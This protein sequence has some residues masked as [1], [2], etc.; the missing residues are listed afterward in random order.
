MA[1]RAAAAL[2]L[3]QEQIR[4]VYIGL[5][6]GA[7]RPASAD[8]TWTRRYGD[9]KAK[10]ALLLALL[11]E[12]GI[13]A[14]AVLVNSGGGDGMDERLPALGLFDHVVVRAV[15]DGRTVWLDGTRSGD[16]RLDLLPPP[17]FV[18]ALP[19]RAADATLEKVERKPLVRPTVASLIE[20][21]LSKGVGEPAGLRGEMYLRQDAAIAFRQAFESKPRADVDRSLRALWTQTYEWLEPSAV[22]WRWD[23]R[24]G[25][26]TLT[27]VG[28]GEP[29]WDTGTNAE[30]RWWW[31]E[32][33]QL[34]KPSDFKRPKD[35]DQKA[36]FALPFPSYARQTIVV[37]FPEDA[38]VTHAW[39]ADPIGVSLAGLSLRRNTQLRDRVLLTSSSSRTLSPEVSAEDVATAAK[40]WDDLSSDPVS[41]GIGPVMRRQ[42]KDA[43]DRA[44]AEIRTAGDAVSLADVYLYDDWT[45]RGEPMLDRALALDPDHVDALVRKAELLERRDGPDAAVGVLEKALARI[46]ELDVA[47]A[48]SE[49]HA[50]A[51]RR[52]HATALLRSRL[53]DHPNDADLRTALAARLLID[54]DPAAA[55]EQLNVAD[56]LTGV[57]PESERLRGEALEYLERYEEAYAHYDRML[58][59][60]PDVA[61]YNLYRGRVSSVL[62]RNEAALDDL[63]E[64]IRIDPL[65]PRAYAEK[66][67]LLGSLGRVDDAIATAEL[68]VRRAPKSGYASNLRCWVKA[69]A[70]RDL[71]GAE[72]DCETASK[73]LPNEP[74]VQDSRALLDFRAG[75]LDEAR[76][77]YDLILAGD[78]GS[79]SA[80]YGRGL[81]RLKAGDAAG[82]RADID[83]AKA[84]DALTVADY[85]AF[86]LVEEP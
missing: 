37:R 43:L 50:R 61:A 53:K 68:G 14:E 39:K 10:T 5:D 26:L 47:V 52:E 7:Y 78:P 25:E 59:A 72:K 33:T 3:V 17:T 57:T 55:L 73:R 12:L 77:K 58:Q 13:E 76:R 64:A 19:I 15:V 86:G 44:E 79:V 11:R 70:G 29:D 49:L 22:D 32:G 82:G 83:K 67:M 85:A 40:V 80:L 4:Y 62:R 20:I 75:R 46:E 21:D 38:G 27:V 2:Q 51:G 28:E 65:D 69:I 1:G 30:W 18:W 56:K 23:E 31:I 42:P 16:R 6:D 35:E 41:V 60:R 63:E 66:A 8:E 48:L 45:E 36:P 9:C 54:R 84:A 24:S 34:R 81:V 74:A 71:A